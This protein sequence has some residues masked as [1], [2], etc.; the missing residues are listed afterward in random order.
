MKNKKRQ[1]LARA[2]KR[3]NAIIEFSKHLN[4]HV[5][6]YKKH[7]NHSKFG[8]WKRRVELSSIS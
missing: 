1:S 4:Q 5:A 6:V 2:I 8:G 3:G 7:T